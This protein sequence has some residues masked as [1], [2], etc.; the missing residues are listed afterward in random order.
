MDKKKIDLYK[1]SKEELLLLKNELKEAQEKLDNGEELVEFSEEYDLSNPDEIYEEILVNISFE[2][3]RIREQK[4]W[5]QTELANG[6][7]KTQP[8]ISKIENLTSDNPKIKTLVDI[9]FALGKTLYITPHKEY[10]YTVP[11]KTREAIDKKAEETGTS[12][13]EIIEKSFDKGF[14]YYDIPLSQYEDFPNQNEQ[15][16][17]YN[18]LDY[19]IF[20]NSKE[21]A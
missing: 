12:T 13:N 5:S 17:S 1:L 16:S 21:V 3:T 18:E 7:G 6:S 4:G 20:L 9:F 11:E 8:K 14:T 10:T 15:Y 2:L 19:K